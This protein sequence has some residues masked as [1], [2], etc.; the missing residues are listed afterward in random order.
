[1]LENKI[2]DEPRAIEEH[3]CL[4]FDK[5]G[6][7]PMSKEVGGMLMQLLMVEANNLDTPFEDDVPWQIKAVKK[8]AEVF[9]LKISNTAIVFITAVSDGNIGNMI[10]Y[11]VYLKYLSNKYNIDEVTVTEI[12]STLF[13]MGFPSEEDMH[14]LWDK[15]KISGSPDNLIDYPS[16]GE[17][18]INYKSK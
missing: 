6:R 9:N 15:Q 2:K 8:R 13:P 1:M 12:A 10:M 18:I 14:M 16:A 4:E 5:L 7:E 11:V 17:T 3:F